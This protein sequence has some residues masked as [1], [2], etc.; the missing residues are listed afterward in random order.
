MVVAK[1]FKWE[2]AHRIPWHNGKCKHLHGHSYKMIVEFEGELND[3]GI[4][5]DFNDLKAMVKSHIERIDH[6][7]IISEK[8]SELKEVFDD[9]NWKYYLLP[10]DSTAEN[11]CKY[12]ANLII[13][14][15]EAFLLSNKIEWV[16]VKI[17][18]TETAYAYTKIVLGEI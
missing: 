4:V 5:I 13:T 11:L 8:D 18:E 2:A 17:Y 3:N 9:K 12:F 7:T 6:T 14:E 16:G 1:H 10:F 15:N